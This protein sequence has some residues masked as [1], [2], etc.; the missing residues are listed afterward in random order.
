MSLCGVI[1]TRYFLFQFEADL[2]NCLQ[3]TCEISVS[4]EEMMSSWE[5]LVDPLINMAQRRKILTSVDEA[6]LKFA[7]CNFIFA[8]RQGCIARLY[9]TWW[10]AG[11]TLC[12]ETSSEIECK[13]DNHRMKVT[14]QKIDF[15]K[16]RMYHINVTETCSDEASKNWKMYRLC[17]TITI[18]WPSHLIIVHRSW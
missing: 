15:C 10:A 9:F 4:M 18:S 13:D 1:F 17:W 2:L 12:E 11:F 6:N 7:T 5:K 3:Q 8:L 14:T 16:I